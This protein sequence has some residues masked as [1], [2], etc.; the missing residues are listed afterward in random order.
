MSFLAKDYN[1]Y[2]ERFMQIRR[3]ARSVIGLNTFNCHFVQYTNILVTI[4]KLRLFLMNLY[5]TAL[6]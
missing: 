2:R 6:M 5:C 1:M 3:Q 4:W